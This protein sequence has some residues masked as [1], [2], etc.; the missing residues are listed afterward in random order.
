[1]VSGRLANPINRYLLN[2]PMLPQVK[3]DAD[4]RRTLYIQN[5]SPGNGQG[6][7]LASRAQAASSVMPDARASVGPQGTDGPERSRPQARISQHCLP[8]AAAPTNQKTIVLEMPNPQRSNLQIRT[9]RR[10]V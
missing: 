3:L 2:S 10:F 5:E 7:Q 1:M 6:G 8:L 9:A 4:G